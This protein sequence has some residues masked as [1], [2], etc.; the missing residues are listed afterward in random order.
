MERLFRYSSLVFDIDSTLVTIEG[1]D[2]LARQKG[3]FEEVA[4]LTNQAMNG[5]V[6]FQDIFFRR[7]ALIRP[8]KKDIEAL[9]DLYCST[10]TPGAKETIEELGKHNVHVFIVSGSYNP[11]AALLARHLGIPSHH[12]FANEILFD[13]LG[14]Y[15]GIDTTIP[16]WRQDGKKHIVRAIKEKTRGNILVVGDGASDRDATDNTC[17]FLCFAGVA[18]RPAVIKQS[19][20]AI[21]EPSLLPVLS[22]AFS[23]AD[24]AAKAVASPQA[25]A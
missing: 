17:D 3:V 8:T 6:D 16:L 25:S 18:A 19:V 21:K 7:L 10:L 1:I 5:A 20:F 13:Q 12:V 24:E 2:E 14:H 9:G 22:F 15:T 4:M 11:A 23:G